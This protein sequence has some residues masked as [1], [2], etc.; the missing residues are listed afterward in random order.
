[1]DGV[2][3]KRA[4]TEKDHEQDK[5]YEQAHKMTLDDLPIF[6][7]HLVNDYSHDYGTI[8]HAI[9]AGAV[10][11]ANAINSSDAGGITGFQASAV[12]WEFITK[13]ANK[14]GPLRLLEYSNMLYPQ[15]GHTYWTI[16]PDTWKWLQEQAAKKLNDRDPPQATAEVVAHWQ[17]IVNGR[18]PFGYRI[19]ER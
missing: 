7:G 14:D 8:C 15:Y 10:A 17:S 5:W 2:G 1:V 12:M 18:V 4:I 19:E 6:L 11:A 3:T 13:W 9:A 16:S